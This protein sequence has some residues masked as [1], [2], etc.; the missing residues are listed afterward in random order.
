MADQGMTEEKA[1]RPAEPRPGTLMR[2]LLTAAVVTAVNAGLFYGL[3][4][5]G[6]TLRVPASFGSRD[7]IDM[8]VVPAV[9]ATV[10]AS[11]GGVAFALLLRNARNGRTWFSWVTVLV[12]IASLSAL[13]TLDSPIIDRA[14]QG[15]FHLVPAASLLAL[16]G[17]SLKR[18]G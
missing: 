6:V 1:S 4:Q 11:L 16:V 3:N 10:I 12:A 8:T 14:A 13:T 7:L 5:S 9:V 18:E 17:S 2:G 15:L